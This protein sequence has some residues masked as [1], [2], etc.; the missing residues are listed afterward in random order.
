MSFGMHVHMCVFLTHYHS[1]VGD[2]VLLVL[3][4]SLHGLD[5]C[6]CM[7]GRLPGMEMIPQKQTFSTKMGSSWTSQDELTPCPLYQGGFLAHGTRNTENGLHTFPA[8]V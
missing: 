4:T 5:C 6:K 1:N 8:S 7:F 3:Y 2:G